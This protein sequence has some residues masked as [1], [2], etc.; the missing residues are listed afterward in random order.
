MTDS[1]RSWPPSLWLDTAQ[2]MRACAPLAANQHT[3][4][5]IVGAGFTGLSAALHLAEAGRSA[6]VLEA[7]QPGWGASGRNGGQVN[8]GWKLLP[9]D[10]E[11]IHGREP[12]RRIVSM[13]GGACDLVFDLIEKHGIACDAVRPGYVQ[14]AESKRGIALLESWVRQWSARGA[15]VSLL[16]RREAV[17][18]LG[19]EA[20]LG[21]ML[22]RRGGN[23]QPLR[24]LRG[25]CQAAMA[26]GVPVYGDSP[27]LC[28]RRQGSAWKLETADATLTAEQVLICTNGYTGT[29]WPGLK[30]AVVPVPSFVAASEPLDFKRLAGILPGRHAVSETRRVQVY[31]RTDAGGRFVIGGR[32]HLFDA[33]EM[34][35]IRHVHAEARRLFPALADVKWPYH[36]GGYTAMTLSHAPKLMQLSPG[37]LAG[38]GYNGRGIAMATMMGKQMAIAIAG[39][40]PDMPVEPM[41]RIPFHSLRQAGL[42]FRLVAGSFLDRCERITER[43]AGMRLLEDD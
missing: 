42:S 8:P 34:G 3:Q 14:G 17:E 36:W 6:C 26:A 39:R 12:G 28:L 38:M 11:K 13:A 25:L 30:T 18:L 9:D 35:D 15:P 20:Y 7:V 33:A 27:A 37:L 31:Y 40:A 43:R 32:G 24:Y 2:P 23:I 4:V 29:L 22:D 10:I 21:A 16:S 41:T 19:T 1:M 5:A